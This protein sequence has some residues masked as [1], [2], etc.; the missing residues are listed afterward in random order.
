MTSGGGG[1]GAFFSVQVMETN[2][3]IAASMACAIGRR[4][5]LDKR[6]KCKDAIKTSQFGQDKTNG[7]PDRNSLPA[8]TSVDGMV[9]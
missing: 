1:G 6:T 7:M 3:T 5:F 9:R 8:A 2:P 4:T